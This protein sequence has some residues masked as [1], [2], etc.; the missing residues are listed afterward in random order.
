MK[1]RQPN[2]PYNQSEKNAS[3][4]MMS[5]DKT[6]LERKMKRLAVIR[7]QIQRSRVRTRKRIHRGKG[8]PNQLGNPR[9][10]STSL[11]HTGEVEPPA[12]IG[13]FKLVVRGP[14]PQ[15]PPKKSLQVIMKYAMYSTIDSLD[16]RENSC[17]NSK[18]VLLSG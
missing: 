3:F 15:S 8:R 18:M 10:L 11:N 7:T 12:A 14:Q 9:R 5:Y 17:F 4:V 1:L 16:R 13:E 2:P 6:K